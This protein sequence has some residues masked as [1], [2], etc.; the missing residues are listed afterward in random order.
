MRAVPRFR[1]ALL[2]VVLPLV[3]G[4]ASYIVLRTWAPLI[5]VHAALWP[6][7]P[8]LVRDHFAD[9][10]WGWALGGFVAA[11]WVGES[12]KHRIVWTLAAAVVAACF[13]LMQWRAFDAVDLV[14]Q[15]SAVIVAG[16]MIGGKKRW[17]LENAAH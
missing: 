7:A 5:G 2:H 9:A 4:S 16:V 6:H 17:T 15:T 3:L 11:M 14:V 8:A 10:A 13:E 1:I 12:P